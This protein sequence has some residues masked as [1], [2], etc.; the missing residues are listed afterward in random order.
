[1]LDKGYTTDWMTFDPMF[2]ASV[3]LTRL[4]AFSMPCMG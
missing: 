1:M 3:M 2:A 4:I